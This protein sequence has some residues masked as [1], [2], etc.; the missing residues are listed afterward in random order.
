MEGNERDAAA[1]V[2]EAVAQAQS[3]GEDERWDEAYRVLLDAL[4]TA[5]EDPL[6]LTWAG[7][8]AQRLGEE[9]E[10]YEHFRR[11]LAGEP[12]DPF[13]LAAAGSGVAALDDPGAESALRLAALTAPDFP[14]AR[15]AYGAYLAREGLFAEAAVELEAACRLAP[16]DANAHADLGI[17]YLL[18]GRSGEGLE[19][20]EGALALS[21]GDSW[22]RGV[23]GL[24]LVDAGRGE[25]GAEHLHAA[26]EERVEDVEVQL[27]A[28]LAMGAQG[29]ESSAWEA[30]AR[31]AAAADGSERELVTEVEDALEAG[32]EAA[33]RLLREDLAPSFLRERLLQRD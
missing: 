30:A 6:L 18:G 15:A 27:V 9:G 8:T 17:T 4:G 12:Q 10:A 31:A 13:V 7:L 11:A 16:E 5:G 32:P 26:A 25:E 29:W 1:A 23:L 19:T 20:L 33:E 3:L 14:F 2:Q 24:A 22:L 28:A 21:A